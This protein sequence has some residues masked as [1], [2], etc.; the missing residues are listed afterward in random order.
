MSLTVQA[1]LT[2]QL[3]EAR[4]EWRLSKEDT[5]SLQGQ[6]DTLHKQVALDALSSQA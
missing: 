5:K 4:A 1:R 3:K 2:R 6:L